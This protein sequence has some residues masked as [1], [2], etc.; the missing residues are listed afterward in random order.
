MKN[1]NGKTVACVVAA[2]RNCDCHLAKTLIG[3]VTIY[4][5]KNPELP[6]MVEWNSIQYLEFCKWLFAEAKLEANEQKY[7]IR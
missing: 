4:C 3:A 1:E 2:K 5:I 7:D 6:P